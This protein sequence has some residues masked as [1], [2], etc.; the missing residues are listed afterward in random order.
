[1]TIKGLMFTRTSQ[2]EVIKNEKNI[3]FYIKFIDYI[4]YKYMLYIKY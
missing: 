3:K 1:M 4:L 2:L